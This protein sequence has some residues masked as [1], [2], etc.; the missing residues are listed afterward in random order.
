V[1]EAFDGVFLSLFCSDC[2]SLL[3]HLLLGLY[4]QSLGIVNAFSVPTSLGQCKMAKICVVDMLNGFPV[5]SENF[6]CTS[7]CVELML[8][9]V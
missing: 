7:Q 2:S 9:N 3:V 8:G 1:A 6:K 5:K 4:A